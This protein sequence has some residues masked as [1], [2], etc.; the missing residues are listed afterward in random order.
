MFVHLNSRTFRRRS[1]PSDIDGLI[2]FY[3][4]KFKIT[5]VLQYKWTP[6]I[7]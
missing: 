3:E 1:R 2:I 6:L 7:G 4:F 5:G